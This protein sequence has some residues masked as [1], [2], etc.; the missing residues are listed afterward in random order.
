V[1][2]R[3]SFVGA[4]GS[5]PVP[6][7][8]T[9][10]PA[11]D[12]YLIPG[13]WDSHIHTLRLSPQLHFP[14]LVA[15][16]I[17]SVRDMG[18][19]C[20]WSGSADCE[21]ATP[22]WRTQIQRGEIAGPRI[23]ESV[24]YHLEEVP[25]H[26]AELRGLIDTLKRRGERSLKIQMD[27]HVAP[28]DFAKVMG[29]AGD[30]GFR[31]SGHIPFSV[32]LMDGVHPL[33]SI[34]HDWSLLPQCSDFRAQFDGKNRSKAALLAGMNTARCERVLHHLNKQ[35][36]IYTPTH[37]AS[38]GQDAAFSEGTPSHARPA[39]RYVIAPQRWIWA[40]M[41][42]AGKEGPEEQKVLKDVH[43]AALRLTKQA[44]E[45]GV[46]VLAG[47]DALDADMI[48]GFSLHQELQN[49]VAAGL[50]PAQALVAATTG[51]ARA[52][53]L[54]S[55]LGLIEPG[56]Y[57]D[58]VLLDANPLHDIRN[59]QRISAVVADGRLYGKQERASAMRF[60]EDQ[61]HRISVI[62]RYLRGIWFEG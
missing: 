33:G 7:G 5:R 9:V 40:L 8:A 18:D 1:G 19:T 59:T 17:T 4:N 37:I 15:N 16:G 29:A 11:S 39:Q 10:I 61:A 50:T 43:Q 42:S 34:E 36:W 55:Q 49:L 58:M 60:V 46:T 41:R 44:Q 28:A 26:D 47:S 31:V 13:L 30:K 51:P 12:K 25:E 22:R 53:G 3:I 54:E 56:K 38:S 52:Q 21:P 27:D 35:G 23:V 14:L 48:H 45:A 32:D 24:S 2:D 20:S 57:A 6:E 62:C